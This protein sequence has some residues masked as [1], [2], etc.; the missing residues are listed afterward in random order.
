MRK[1]IICLLLLIFVTSVSYAKIELP[2]IISDHMVL[3]QNTN[4]KL[5]GKAKINSTVTIT[6]SWNS[7]K[8]STRSNSDGNWVIRIPTSKATYTPQS[9]TFSDGEK[10]IINNIL[11][12]EV[13]FCAGQS[14]ME[15]TLNG[16][17][18]CPVMNANDDI[19]NAGQYKGIRCATVTRAGTMTPQTEAKG[20]WQE[21]TPENAPGFSAVAFHFATSLN[22]VLDVP[23]GI[24]CCSWGGSTVEGWLPREILQNYPDIDLSEEGF[25]KT[26][27]RT[28]MRPMIMY[29]GMLK[30]MQNY[31]IK[32]FLWYQ[33]EAN[34]NRHQTYA[35]RLAA[36]VELWRKE[37]GLG[38]LPFY[39]VEIAPYRYGNPQGTPAAYLRE[40]QFKSQSII[41]NSGMIST[42]DLV[43]PYEY[44]NVHPK[45]K[46]IVGKRLCYMALTNTYHTKGICAH[47]P[48]YRSMEIKDGKIILNFDH[49]EGYNRLDK[50]TG[51]EIAGAD[52]VFHPAEA[53]VYGQRQ[54]IVS[55]DTVPNPEAVRYC[56]RNFQLGNVCNQ[57]ELP[58]IPFRT[59]DWE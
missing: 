29:N 5:W 57:R 16:F 55:N 12:G 58:L 25:E 24:I 28:Y 48:S 20:K 26:K 33:G 53:K 40:A 39:Q 21:S 30:P 32:G 10:T 18:N 31:T 51:F 14:N 6:T 22:K 38:E 23:V 19:A 37:W 47:S 46:T 50:M 1:I 42:N 3:Q 43:E 34:V 2:E 41:P 17:N 54:I 4:V 49:A 59:D 36:M 45:N 7:Q 8:Y 44:A 11:I 27:N 15:M 35:Q 9:I 52:K 56:F 13:W